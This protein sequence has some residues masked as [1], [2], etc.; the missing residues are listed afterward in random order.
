MWTRPRCAWCCST[1]TAAWAS[2][3]ARTRPCWPCSA[4]RTNTTSRTWWASAWAR[5][6]PSPAVMTSRR[7]CRRAE[8]CTLWRCQPQ[9]SQKAECKLTLPYFTSSQYPTPDAGKLVCRVGGVC[10]Q[11]GVLLLNLVAASLQA[12][13]EHSS[14]ELR[15]ACLGVA[16]RCLPNVVISATFRELLA[17]QPYLAT[18]FLHEAALR[19]KCA[20]EFDQDFLPPRR[21]PLCLRSASILAV[22]LSMP[23]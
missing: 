16:A 14:E 12:A 17:A 21:A 20:C 6:A 9:V 13:S 7:C 5:W 15:E 19:A 10:A 23:L 1:A 8:L 2:C 18:G 11:R 22:S 4:R 3:R